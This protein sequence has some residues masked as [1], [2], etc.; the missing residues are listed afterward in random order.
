[1]KVI[2]IL[3]FNLFFS[4][5]LIGFIVFS[6]VILS[7]SARYIKYHFIS[8]NTD[9][10]NSSCLSNY[11]NIKWIK[12]H[13]IEYGKIRFHYETPIVYKADIFNGETIN[14]E[15]EYNIRRTK[16]KKDL[17]NNSEQAYF[18][19][20]SVMWGYGSNDKNTIPSHF[21]NFSDI[22]SYNFGESA[23]T[24]DQSLMYLIRLLK[25]GH[26][27][28]YVIFYHGVNDYDKCRDTGNHSG[29]LIENKLKIKFKEA[30][31]THAKTTFKIFFSIPI[32][33]IRKMKNI[34]P[35]NKEVDLQEYF[36]RTK[37]IDP[38]LQKKIAHNLTQNW[39]IAND[40]V[41]KYGGKFYAFLEPH[42]YFRNTSLDQISDILSYKEVEFKSFNNTYKNIEKEMED[43]DYFF[44]FKDI[45]N[46]MNE[47]VFIDKVHVSPNGN[48]FSAQKIST[49]IIKN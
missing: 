28:D 33:L 3:F 21:Q 40:L 38:E 47:P 45:F 8:E 44:N 14:I 48:K 5:A 49:I 23:W 4:I 17:K 42:A 16:G 29:I 7:E 2:K 36:N 30:L 9:C 19:G 22:K 35:E 24:S 1:M 10:I 20:G 15:G 26:K 27:P 43:K 13:F 32:E 41:A 34:D 31:R 46:T 12:K 11:K 18:F 6:L 37:C 39:E 25:D